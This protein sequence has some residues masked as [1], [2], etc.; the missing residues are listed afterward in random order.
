MFIFMLTSEDE[1]ALECEGVED[2]YCWG[3]VVDALVVD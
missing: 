1:V 2:A 3:G